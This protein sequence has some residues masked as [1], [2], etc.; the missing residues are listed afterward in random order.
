MTT[1]D[2]IGLVNIIDEC[3]DRFKGRYTPYDVEENAHTLSFLKN[4]YSKIKDGS[5]FENEELLNVYKECVE[6]I[7]KKLNQIENRKIYEYSFN[8]GYNERAIEYF[9]ELLSDLW[10]YSSRKF[11]KTLTENE[12]KIGYYETIDG[13]QV[14]NGY[15]ENI[16]I[17]GVLT[18]E[19]IDDNVEYTIDKNPTCIKFIGITK[20]DDEPYIQLFIDGNSVGS[21]YYTFDSFWNKFENLSSSDFAKFSS[22]YALETYKVYFAFSQGFVVND[23]NEYENPNGVVYDIFESLQKTLNNNGEKNFFKEYLKRYLYTGLVSRYREK[24]IED[25]RTSLVSEDLN[26][27][28][29]DKIVP[30]VYETLSGKGG[31]IGGVQTIN[32]DYK[33]ELGISKY[34]RLMFDSSYY[35]P[36]TNKIELYINKIYL[37]NNLKRLARYNGISSNNKE[38]YLSYLKEKYSI[39]KYYSDSSFGNDETINYLNHE[40]EIERLLLKEEFFAI[41]PNFWPDTNLVNKYWDQDF[42]INNIKSLQ[43]VYF[44]NNEHYLLNDEILK[45]LNAVE[46]VAATKNLNNSETEEEKERAKKN[47][48]RIEENIDKYTKSQRKTNISIGSDNDNLIIYLQN[49]VSFSNKITEKKYLGRGYITFKK[50]PQKF[51]DNKVSKLIDNEYTNKNIYFESEEFSSLLDDRETI[52]VHLSSD[53]IKLHQTATGY[54]PAFKGTYLNCIKNGSS[55]SFEHETIDYYKEL[56]FPSFKKGILYKA[57]DYMELECT[58]FADRVDIGS[59]TQIRV[60]NTSN[61]KDRFLFNVKG[62]KK[63]YKTYEKEEIIFDLTDINNDDLSYSIN[64]IFKPAGDIKY[65]IKNE[66]VKIDKE[67]ANEEILITKDGEDYTLTIN[68]LVDAPDKNYV[69]DTYTD[70]KNTINN[71]S[72]MLNDQNDVFLNKNTEEGYYLDLSSLDKITTGIA[73]FEYRLILEKNEYTK[74]VDIDNTISDDGLNVYIL[75]YI[76]MSGR[77]IRKELQYCTYDNEGEIDEENFTPNKEKYFLYFNPLIKNIK[78]VSDKPYIALMKHNSFL[79]YPLKLNFDCVFDKGTCNIK[80]KIHFNTDDTIKKVKINDI[81]FSLNKTKFVFPYKVYNTDIT[82]IDDKEIVLNPRKQYVQENNIEDTYITAETKYDLNLEKYLFFRLMKTYKDGDEI[83][84]VILLEDKYGKETDDED[85]GDT[86]LELSV[87]HEIVF[88]DEDEGGIY[89]IE[90]PV[91]MYNEIKEKDEI[92]LNVRSSGEYEDKEEKDPTFDTNLGQFNL[93]KK[94]S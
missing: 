69:I 75:D 8:V 59:I 6:K 87:Q 89:E 71:T 77:P 86:E 35:N 55:V 54:V 58:D 65:S 17:G 81:Y 37:N 27:S 92:K 12:R 44:Y 28:K 13:Q 43:K 40:E 18:P 82:V 21:K 48:K 66:I 94:Q 50:V 85:R 60:M 26:F 19:Y 46:L 14:F 24:K 45:E 53:N 16:V 80:E 49:D 31:N 5:I 29:Y 63:V 4:A 57:N 38:S 39:L 2:T 52:A 68:Q 33:E 7:L 78:I 76:Q 72:I 42:F 10:K 79:I 90:I 41:E 67:S 11:S 36:E 47:L 62:V 93:I 83:K 30:G 25:N 88:E 15:R 70:E 22:I 1:L 73:F 64:S 84:N 51:K 34:Q 20:E 56:E 61:N 74:Y 3:F 9:H 32:F 23:M 91:I